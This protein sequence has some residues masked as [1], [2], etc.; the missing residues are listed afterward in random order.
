MSLHW[1]KCHQLNRIMR[2]VETIVVHHHSNRSNKEITL[3]L[4]TNPLGYI[5]LG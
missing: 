5:L 4:L 3:V 1:N 2:S